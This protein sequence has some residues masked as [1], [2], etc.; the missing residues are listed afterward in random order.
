MGHPCFG[1]SRGRQNVEARPPDLVSANGSSIEASTA[2]EFKHATTNLGELKTGVELDE[3]GGHAQVNPEEIV[4]LQSGPQ[5]PTATEPVVS[6]EL[7]LFTTNL[8]Q[9]TTNEDV[10]EAI[11]I[12]V[13]G[14]YVQSSK[15]QVVKMQC[16]QAAEVALDEMPAAA[17]RLVERIAMLQAL[18]PELSEKSQGEVK[19]SIGMLVKQIE[20]LH[21]ASLLVSLR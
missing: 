15:K 20:A 2:A 14:G 17:Q 4:K 12:A 3:S 8:G 7:T 13:V 16:M 9:D 5:L 21:A 1:F 10:D 18:L 6:A 19:M 11:S